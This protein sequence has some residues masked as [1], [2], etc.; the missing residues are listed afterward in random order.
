ML[1]TLFIHLS[2]NRRFRAFAERSP[3]GRRV[4]RRF[5]AGLTIEEALAAEIL[6]GEFRSMTLNHRAHGAIEHENARLQRFQKCGAAAVHGGGD[7]ESGYAAQI[8]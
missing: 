7:N 5:V 3:L 8:M 2:A 1:R 4:A 6:L